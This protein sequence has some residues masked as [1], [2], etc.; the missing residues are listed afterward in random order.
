[1][2]CEMQRQKLARRRQYYWCNI[3]ITV[4]TIVLLG[5]TLPMPCT[6]TSFHTE[7]MKVRMEQ[8]I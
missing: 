8:A 1:M 7:N 4:G 5:R 2:K 3:L 6:N